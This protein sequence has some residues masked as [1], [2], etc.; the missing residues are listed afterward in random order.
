MAATSVERLEAVNAQVSPDL[1]VVI[2]S[3]R[4]DDFGSVHYQ[5][6]NIHR[7]NPPALLFEV[8][9]DFTLV[10]GTADDPTI[11]LGTWQSRHECEP[12]HQ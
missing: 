4:S 7:G 12:V 2:E 9:S 11:G 6:K 3:H 5:L 10:P 8:P 1:D